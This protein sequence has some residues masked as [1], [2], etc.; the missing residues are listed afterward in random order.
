M[1]EV[2]GVETTD[3]GR[4]ENP[5]GED[6]TCWLH[7]TPDEPVR[8]EGWRGRDRYTCPAEGCGFSRLDN[9]RKPDARSLVEDH[10][11]KAHDI[12]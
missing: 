3:G 11:R 2:C 4:C 6:G 8:S 7:G 12:V 10:M 1:S 9:P 5:A